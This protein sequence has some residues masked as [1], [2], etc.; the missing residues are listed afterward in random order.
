MSDT[1]SKPL[2]QMYD[3]QANPVLDPLVVGDLVFVVP[4]ATSHHEFYEEIGVVLEIVEMCGMPHATV[5][6]SQGELARYAHWF[7][8]QKPVQDSKK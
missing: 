6:F 2:W 1:K 7:S 5:R 8:K 4:G 3:H